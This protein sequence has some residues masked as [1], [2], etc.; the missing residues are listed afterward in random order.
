MLVQHFAAHLVVHCVATL[1]YYV[2]HGDCRFLVV[3]LGEGSLRG[4]VYSGLSYVWGVLLVLLV[5]P[6]WTPQTPH[7]IYD[8]VCFGLEGL[9]SIL[10][11]QQIL[12]VCASL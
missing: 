9:A 2:T 6:L 7:L 11:P 1:S 8:L 5:R 4:M 10:S 12:C 3:V